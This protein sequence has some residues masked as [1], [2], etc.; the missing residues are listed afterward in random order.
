M[1]SEDAVNSLAA[2]VCSAFALI[3]LVAAGSSCDFVVV[4]SLYKETGGESTTHE[5]SFGVFCQ[6]SSDDD[7]NSLNLDGDLML[8]M[9]RILLCMAIVLG[10]I[11]TWFAWSITFWK[12][13]TRGW[14]LLISICAS[15]AAVLCVPVFLLFE[16]KP[17]T[18]ESQTCEFSLGAYLLAFSLLFW[19]SVTIITQCLDPAFGQANSFNDWRMQRAKKSRRGSLVQSNTDP[20]ISWCHAKKRT[21]KAVASGVYVQVDRTML[22]ESDEEEQRSVNAVAP[23]NKRRQMSEVDQEAAIG[24]TA[25][26]TLLFGE[27]AS[28][29]FVVRRDDRSEMSFAEQSQATSTPSMEYSIFEADAPSWTRDSREPPVVSLDST[30]GGKRVHTETFVGSAPS[31]S[32]SAYLMPPAGLAPAL[33][34]K[35][36]AIALASSLGH[37]VT[38][39]SVLEDDEEQDSTSEES[40]DDRMSPPSSSSQSPPPPPRFDLAEDQRDEFIRVIRNVELPALADEFDD[41]D[42]AVDDDCDGEDRGLNLSD[43]LG[44]LEPTV[45]DLT[46]NESLLDCST[47]T[48]RS[49]LPSIK[50]KTHSTDTSSISL[51]QTMH[52]IL[53]APVQIFKGTGKRRERFLQDYKLLDDNDLERSVPMSS[54]PLEILTIKVSQQSENEL[55]PVVPPTKREQE[56]FDKWVMDN[57]TLRI[58]R[59][60]L[61]PSGLEPDLNIAIYDDDNDDD[62]SGEGT[63]DKE[64]A[65]SRSRGHG[66]S[67]RL[68]SSVASGGS[69]LLSMPIA[70]ATMEGLHTSDAEE[71]N[72][73]KKHHPLIRTRS[74]P[75]LAAVAQFWGESS[76]VADDLKMTGVNSYYTAEIFR[77][78]GSSRGSQAS[79][80]M[81]GGKKE[82]SSSHHQKSDEVI[83]I[84]TKHNKEKPIF[85]QE[86]A[87]KGAI[88]RSPSYISDASSSDDN[89]SLSSRSNKKTEKARNARIRRLQALNDNFVALQ[90]SDDNET[91]PI[92]C[93]NN[94][95]ERMKAR[96][97]AAA[98][99]AASSE[100]DS[101]SERSTEGVS[102]QVQ[103]EQYRR[104]ELV[105]S[106]QRSVKSSNGTVSSFGSAGSFLIDLLDV[107]LAE[108]YRPDG[109]LKGPDEVSL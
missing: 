59:R 75:N 49:K 68:A 100:S 64:K 44:S 20:C 26:Q 48:G 87:L 53:Y 8:I 65:D 15:L 45:F 41:E 5:A 35:D 69:S 11:G 70:E 85:R 96:Y 57:R 2:A 17:C 25:S 30:N 72:L 102:A 80:N 73:S 40:S 83:V 56:L 79:R 91:P 28:Q 52:R 27:T 22:E 51:N 34:A 23:S 37:S 33:E 71:D 104:A 58:D 50:R 9:C 84:A 90:A 21:K 97:H 31:P 7:E 98:A 77:G 24:D 103:Q 61:A 81:D 74:A 76:T 32:N 46:G 106:P 82:E 67:Q 18:E 19:V 10:T 16:A 12:V 78:I 60:S 47:H 3:L 14:W 66:Q 55:S 92:S 54:P 93:Q 42:E 101:E 4:E 86:R 88:H 62:G 36:P 99:A 109:E 63:L 38:L 89:A 1:A 94:L 107:Q 39:E 13:P 95:L 29:T 6:A 108:L 43:D 105:A